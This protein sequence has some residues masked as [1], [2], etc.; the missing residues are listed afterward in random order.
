MQE[1][2]FFEALRLLEGFTPG[3]SEYPIAT[4]NKLFCFWIQSAETYFQLA[5][6]YS[7]LGRLTEAEQHY[8]HALQVDPDTPRYYVRLINL[9]TAWRQ[10]ILKE[11]LA[12]YPENIVFK[13]L[14]EEVSS[15]HER[16]D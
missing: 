16:T 5:E 13:K 15:N 7:H 2:R 3:S 8:K 12:K 4:V 1:R 14:A 9:Y 11:A 6:I 10:N